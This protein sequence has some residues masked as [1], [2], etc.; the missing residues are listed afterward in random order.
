MKNNQKG[1]TLVALV[2]T[3]IVLLILAGVTIAALSGENGIL[4]RA[5]QSTVETKVSQAKEVIT[6]A[7]NAAVADYYNAKYVNGDTAG[8]SNAQNYVATAM[9]ADTDITGYALTITVTP[10]DSTSTA[11]FTVDGVTYTGTISNATKGT[12]IAWTNNAP[13][14]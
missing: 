14:E 4:K 8:T 5:S 13:A 9:A 7:Y 6:T 11:V 3:I 12:S 10:G 1:I 2:I